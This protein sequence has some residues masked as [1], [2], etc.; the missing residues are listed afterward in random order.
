MPNELVDHFFRHESGKLI[1]SLVRF[2]G[3]KHFDLVED[4]VQAALVEALRVWKIRGVPDQPAA[5]I[6]RV[7][8]NRVLDALRRDKNF[9]EKAEELARLGEAKEGQ[10]VENLF[11]ESQLQDSQLR[12]IFACCHSSLPPDSAVP[13]TLKT[14]CG[15]SEE[16]VA[17]G[18]LLSSENVRKRIY[19]AKQTMIED[20]ISLDLPSSR[21]LSARLH[22]VHTV[23]YLMFNEGYSSTSSDQAIRDDVCEEAA[24]LCHLLTEHPHCSTKTTSALLALMLFHASRFDARIDSNGGF[25]L[26]D[27]Q[28]RTK[29]DQRMISRAKEYLQA[30][31]GPAISVY[32]LEAAIALQH[33][34]AASFAKTNWSAIIGLYDRLIERFPSSVY[35]LNRAIAINQEMG[36]EAAIEIL[37]SIQSDPHLNRFHLLDATY[38]EFY[39]AKSQFNLAKKHFEKAI[40]KTTSRHEQEVLQRRIAQCEASEQPK[41]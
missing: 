13:L 40:L 4:M 25:V 29:W 12:L 20:K 24:R 2:F 36:P 1:A 11:D 30:S 27:E 39:R 7:A 41:S 23:L 34:V 33:C 6:H 10:R 21:Q 32:H 38:G 28:D 19:R 22:Y 3:L 35:Q 31:D 8:K 9:Q 37:D 5:W 16:E 26:L 17:R 15:F 18:M 14:L